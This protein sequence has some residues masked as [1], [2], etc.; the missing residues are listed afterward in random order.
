MGYCKCTS[1]PYSN[2]DKTEFCPIHNEYIF[3]DC[4]IR[5]I[6]KLTKS[7]DDL[8]SKLNILRIRT[9]I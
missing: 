6:E 3:R 4:M 8:D 9:K 1:D 2:V 5:S 7:I